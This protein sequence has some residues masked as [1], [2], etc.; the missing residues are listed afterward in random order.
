MRRCRKIPERL[1]Q[2]C[3]TRLL[4]EEELQPLKREIHDHVAMTFRFGC[5]QVAEVYELLSGEL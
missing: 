4:E 5:D 3:V 2:A 1:Q